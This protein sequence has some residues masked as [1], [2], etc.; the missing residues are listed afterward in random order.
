M[1]MRI[2]ADRVRLERTNRA[3]SQEHLASVTDLG[4][5]TIQRIES[6]GA[7]SNESISAIASAFEMPVATLLVRES[8]PRGNWLTII[9]AKR[10]WIL[11][12]L[13]LVVL[14]FSP[15]EL[16]LA[17]AGLWVW[18]GLEL[19]LILKGRRAPR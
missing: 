7:A 19:M 5:R 15:P 18:A 11:L 17:L 1:D 12:A 6:T 2:D 13:I 9:G 10:L 14:V 4:L 3:W 16:S 8:V